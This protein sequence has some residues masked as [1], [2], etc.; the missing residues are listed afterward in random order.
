VD[1]VYYAVRIRSLGT[2]RFNFSCQRV[3]EARVIKNRNFECVFV[4]LSL[5]NDRKKEETQAQKTGKA[6]QSDKWRSSEI[7]GDVTSSVVS[8]RKEN[9]WRHWK[10]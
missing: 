4:I 2:F 5:G 8:L 6:T 9:V 7:Q 1:C 10:H 3:S